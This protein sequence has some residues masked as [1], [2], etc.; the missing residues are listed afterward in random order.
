MPQW[1]HALDPKEDEYLPMLHKEQE[2][3]EVAPVVRRKLPAGHFRH[4]VAMPCAENLPAAQLSQ[5]KFPLRSLYFPGLH[6]EHDPSL[7][8]AKPAL[9]SHKAALD[10]LLEFNGQSS[11]STSWVPLYFPAEHAVQL[12]C[13]PEV[14]AGQTSWQSSWLSLPAGDVPTVHGLQSV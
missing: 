10:L 12:G 13:T 6:E 8:P 9:H 5:S 3:E 14:P 7:E 2:S 11:Q 4:E 1:T